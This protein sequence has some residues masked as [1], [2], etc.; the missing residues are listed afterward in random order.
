MNLHDKKQEGYIMAVQF[1]IIGRLVP[2]EHIKLFVKMLKSAGIDV[3]PQYLLGTLIIMSVLVSLIFAILIYNVGYTNAFLFGS[4]KVIFEIANQLGLQV[5]ISETP[6]QVTFVAIMLLQDIIS[7]IILGPLLVFLSIYTIIIM[8][9]D[10]RKQKVEEVLPD[11]LMLAAANV[12]AGM[13]IDKALWYAAKPEFGILSLEIELVSRRVFGGQPFD[14][15]IDL[16]V[17]RLD[18]RSVKRAVSLIKQGIASGGE[19]AN[20]LERTGDESRKMQTIRKEISTSL[21]MYIIFIVFASVVATPFLF[22]VSHQL[23]GS[24]E[25]IMNELPDTDNLMGDSNMASQGGIT[26]ITTLFHFGKMPVNSEQ[27]MLFAVIAITIT[28]VFSS[29]IIGTIR[30]GTKIRGVKYIPFMLGVSYTIFFVSSI[31][32]TQL[33]QTIST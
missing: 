13:T 9:A 4:T 25:T 1:E 24:L 17:E 10:N 2:R 23:L 18:S 32:L 28:A 16:L 14:K 33:L 7:S 21:L 22:A 11:F 20:I 19:I 29:L 31:L 5:N 30:H 8:R 26:G 3:S 12:R 15:A 27:F 6:G